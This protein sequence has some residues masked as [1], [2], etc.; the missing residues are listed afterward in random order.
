[1]GMDTEA[2]RWFQQVA[3]GVT[4]TEVAE[5]DMV[6]QP[7]VSR[8]LARLEREVGTPLLQRSGRLLRT[9]RAGAVFKRHV[10]AL[11][12]ALDDGL[13]RGQRARRPGDRHGRRRLPGVAGRLAGARPDRR[14][15]STTTPA[16]GSGSQQSDDALGSSLR[17]RRPPRPRVHRPP[18]AQPGG[19]LGAPLHPAAGAGGA[20]RPT[21]SPGGA[22]SRL[23]DVADED[24]VMLHPSW[25]LR[26][27]TDD[28]CGAAGFTPAVGLRVRRPVRRPRL[29]DRRAR[30][31]G[32]PGRR[33]RT[34]DPHLTGGAAH[35]ARPTTAPTARS[36][37][38]GRRAAGCCPRPSCSASTSSTRACDGSARDDDEFRRLRAGRSD[39][40]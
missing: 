23:A 16:S 31:G 24:F 6:S 40:D 13:R 35:P 21:A 32:D 38:P 18:T 3:D 9:T 4:V 17:R 19:A 11:L 25:A 7:G 30:G 15:P 29:R 1:M 14:V 2:L 27:L 5:L 10:D 39:L 22:G 37:W 12:H 33:A 34:A 28:L 26:T 36:A 20:V 8:A